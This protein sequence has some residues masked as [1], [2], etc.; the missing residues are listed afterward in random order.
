M[1]SWAT[2]GAWVEDSFLSH[3]LDGIPAAVEGC[4]DLAFE[5]RMNFAMEPASAA[6]PGSLDVTMTVPQN[7]SPD[8]RVSAHLKKVVATLPAGVTISPSADGLGACT[9]AQIDLHERRPRPA[10]LLEDRQRLDRHAAA[11]RAESPANIFLGSQDD[12]PYQVAA[13]DLYRRGEGP[14][15]ASS[16]S[17]GGSRSTPRPVS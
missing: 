17:S 5:P 13:R 3:G 16:S 7:E 12:N 11:R 2:P 1:D 6:S 14:E 9:D 8:G 4:E 15:T 10:R